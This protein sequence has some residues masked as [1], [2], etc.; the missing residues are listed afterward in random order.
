VVRGSLEIGDGRIAGPGDVF[1]AGAGTL[2]G[3]H[4]A[5]PEGCTTIEFFGELDGMFRMMYEGPDGD[6]REA[7]SRRGEVSPT[8]VPR[9]SDAAAYLPRPWRVEHH[10]LMG[11]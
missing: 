10:D 5:G 9:P 1:T 8:Y 3:P 6:L 2:Y 7:Y 4:T 11:S